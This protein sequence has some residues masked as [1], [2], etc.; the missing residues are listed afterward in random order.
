MR[1][2]A[3][4]Q[5]GYICRTRVSSGNA[6]NSGAGQKNNASGC[7]GCSLR[8]NIKSEAFVFSP[9]LDLE[10]WRVS[11]RLRIRRCLLYLSGYEGLSTFGMEFDIVV[12]VEARV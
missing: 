11:V 5:C 8:H 2:H 9:W 4:K 1:T 6:E 12:R 3:S 7:E 10:K